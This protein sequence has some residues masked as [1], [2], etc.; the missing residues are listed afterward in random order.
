MCPEG[1][2]ALNTGGT[3]LECLKVKE[4]MD[5]VASR[6]ESRR[7]SAMKGATTELS[8]FEGVSY[9]PKRNVIYAAVSSLKNGM[10]DNQEG[11][12][13]DLSYDIGNDNDIKVAYNKCGCIYTMELDEDSSVTKMSPL[14]CGDPNGGDELNACNIDEIANPD[15]VAYLPGLDVLLIAE[16]TSKH[17]NNILWAFDIDEGSKDRIMMV[18][19]GAEVTSPYLVRISFPPIPP[20]KNPSHH[21]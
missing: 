14:V 9:D 8:K 7:Y 21:K 20:Q 2:E 1:F 5:A 19:K 16:D 18:P 3:G 4:G 10:E 11:G 17:E 12:E 13:D 15:N 6:L